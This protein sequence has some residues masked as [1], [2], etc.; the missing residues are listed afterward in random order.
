MEEISAA[1]CDDDPNRLELA[2]LYNEV[3]FELLHIFRW[4]SADRLLT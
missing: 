2:Q 4:D 3:I 1:A